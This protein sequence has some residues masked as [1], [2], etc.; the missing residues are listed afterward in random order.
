MFA[1]INAKA[2]TQS[3]TDNLALYTPTTDLYNKT[4]IDAL[5]VTLNGYINDKVSTTT[6][7]DTLL[8]Y[9]KLSDLMTTNTSITS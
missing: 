1:L 7:A 8:I 9:A 4:Y 5:A 3:L 2:S 6:L